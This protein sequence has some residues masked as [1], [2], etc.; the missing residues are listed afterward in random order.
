MK[1]RVFQFASFVYSLHER[2]TNFSCTVLKLIDKHLGEGKTAISMSPCCLYASSAN[3]T[4][5]WKTVERGISDI[6][7]VE[8]LLQD[9]H[10]QR[11]FTGCP[12]QC[13]GTDC[14]DHYQNMIG[15]CCL[16]ASSECSPAERS[17]LQQ[18]GLRDHLLLPLCYKRNHFGNLSIFRGQ[19][20][21]YFSQ[22]DLLI[23]QEAARII[24]SVLFLDN[25]KSSD[26]KYYF[27]RFLYD[28]KVGAALLDRRLHILDANASFQEYF[29]YIWKEGTLTG[30]IPVYTGEDSA[31]LSN[32]QKLIYHFG[33]R[34]ITQPAK[35][36]CDCMLFNFQIS[37]KP[38]AY[39][40][41]FGEI[42]TIYLIYVS[43]YKKI[44]SEEIITLLS[45]LT[46][47]ENEVLML[48][49]EGN[50]NN[51]ISEKLY[52]TTHTV[53]AHLQSIYRKLDVTNKTELLTKLYG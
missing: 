42:E 27:R 45:E 48:L 7:L 49:T 47:R 35:L 39:P 25:R 32:S 10:L 20:D 33:Y 8:S 14:S 3:N 6:S 34:I 2:N 5:K 1:D 28:M 53:K 29:E 40:N 9:I 11:K 51:R 50:D 4:F 23:L 31:D 37:T 41:P 30:K 38:L 21:P 24:A 13:S 17:L 19:D 15:F 18:A 43:Q 46:P 22:D 44:E 26:I 16:S 52:I 12:V 36:R